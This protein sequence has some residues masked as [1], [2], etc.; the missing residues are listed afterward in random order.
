MKARFVTSKTESP[1]KNIII[2]VAIFVVVLFGFW[3]LTEKLDKRTT[4]EEA[5][6]LEEALSRGVAQCYALEG[7]YPESLEYLKE[8][9][10]ISYDAD[11]YIVHYSVRGQ[12][13]A[14]SVTIIPREVPDEE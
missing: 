9:Y 8:H 14:P 2:S 12:N 10:G 1:F 5:V 7:S 11:R 4:A 6:R 13:I 3:F